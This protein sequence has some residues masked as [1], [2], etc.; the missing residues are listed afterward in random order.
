MRAMMWQWHTDLG[1][2]PMYLPQ[3]IWID[4]GDTFTIPTNFPLHPDA[5]HEGQAYM[6]DPEEIFKGGDYVFGYYA[7][8]AG[9][10]PDTAVR[11]NDFYHTIAP[12]NDYTALYDAAA[13][14][15]CT[16][17]DGSTVTLTKSAFSSQLAEL[18]GKVANLWHYFDEINLWATTTS[19]EETSEVSLG[20]DYSGHELFARGLNWRDT[21]LALTAGY[22]DYRLGTHNYPKPLYFDGMSYCAWTNGYGNHCEYLS[23]S[24]FANPGDGNME[25]THIRAGTL[26]V[27]IEPNSGVSAGAWDIGFYIFID[28]PIGSYDNLPTYRAV[29]TYRKN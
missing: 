15:V 5:Y 6:G 22:K 16:K 20:F 25:N 27:G 24:I 21:S 7:Y 18:N 9:Q 3:G 26:D 4:D 14:V 28:N 11:I 1:D 12:P 29:F 10:D 13:P 8:N 19:D 23:K 17:G 2:T